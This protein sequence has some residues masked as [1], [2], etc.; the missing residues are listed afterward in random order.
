MP[1]VLEVQMGRHFFVDPPNCYAAFTY[2]GKEFRTET[3]HGATNPKWPKHKCEVGYEGK[4]IEIEFAVMQRKSR[5]E[6]VRIASVTIKW[7]HLVPG[8]RKVDDYAVT[9]EA[10]GV[11]DTAAIRVAATLIP[12]GITG[13]PEEQRENGPRRKALFVGISYAGT[14]SF[15]EFCHEDAWKMKDFFCQPA[16]GFSDTPETVK[17]L[18]D[19][20]NAPEG[21]RPTKENIK[22]GIK[23]LVDEAVAGDSLLFFYSGHGTRVPNNNDREKD[24]YDEALCPIDMEEN[25][26]LVDDELNE[27]LVQPLPAGVRLTCF[28]DACHSGTGMDLPYH[29]SPYTEGTEWQLDQGG[30]YAAA[31]VICVSAAA[32]D[33]TAKHRPDLARR[34]PDHP[35]GAFTSAFLVACEVHDTQCVQNWKEMMTIIK[36]VCKDFRYGQSVQLSSTQSFDLTREFNLHDS[37]PNSNEKMGPVTE[38]NGEPPASTFGFWSK[39]PENNPFAGMGQEEK[40][41]YAAEHGCPA[42]AAIL[43]QMEAFRAKYEKSGTE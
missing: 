18:M 40:L 11:R 33:E 42:S 2:E 35:A 24:G 10:E 12:E 25:G 27:I 31:D 23:W 17:V 3:H 43:A 16:Y 30:Y 7:E 21:E 8:L 37:I 38:G 6:Q 34:R 5:E 15:L 41:R 39:P 32:D 4:P 9:A 28:L 22:A 26:M 13:S 20:E 14:S 1:V 36:N 19:A 29:W